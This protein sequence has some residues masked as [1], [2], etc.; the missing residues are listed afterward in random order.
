MRKPKFGSIYLRGNIYWIKYYKDGKP[1]YESS[2]STTTMRGACGSRRCWIDY[3]VNAKDHKWVERVF[4][5]HVRPYFGE[6]RA[7]SSK[8]DNAVRYQEKRMAEKAKNST[9][10]RELSLLHRAFTLGR[11]SGVPTIV[12]LFPKKLKENNVRKGFFEHD[13][14]VAVRAA[15]TDDIKPIITFA[16]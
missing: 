1:L 8:R 14:F 4:R 15:L 2:E 7:V 12:P 9:I 16:Y 5:K 13:H 6:M 3:K 10:N 11:E